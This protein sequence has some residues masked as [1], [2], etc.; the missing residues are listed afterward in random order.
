MSPALRN[1][2]DRINIAPILYI[3]DEF[4]VLYKTLPLGEQQIRLE[5]MRGGNTPSDVFIE[6]VES[7]A[8]SGATSFS[9]VRCQNFGVNEINLTFNGNSCHGYP[10]KIQNDF[11]LW[12]YIK[13]QD[14]LGSTCNTTISNQIKIDEF[15]NKILFAHKFEGEESSQGWIGVTLSLDKPFSTSKTLGKIF[16]IF[17]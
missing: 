11:P 15:T 12:P 5:H 16:S 6:L 8:F 9:P 7:T 3:Y 13:F 1:F 2:V 17:N 14:V 10:M 4:T